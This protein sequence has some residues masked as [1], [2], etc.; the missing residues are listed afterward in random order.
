MKNIHLKPPVRFVLNPHFTQHYAPA[1][2]FCDRFFLVIVTAVGLVCSVW[3]QCALGMCEEPKNLPDFE[4]QQ[5][6]AEPV[7]P[8][9]LIVD[10]AGE[11]LYDKYYEVGSTIK[12][13]CRI[14][15]MSMLRSAVY[16]IHNENILNHDV[17]RGGI[18]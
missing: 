14:R 17:Q 18:R 1:M 5:N 16:W 9:V 15:H 10:E 11:P 13:I 6:C 7:A 2:T 8:E 12:L 3:P 4:L